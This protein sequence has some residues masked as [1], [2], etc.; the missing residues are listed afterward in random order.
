MTALLLFVTLDGTNYPLASCRWVR[1]APNGCATG[2]H[3]GDAFT[4]PEA[5]AAHFTPGRRDREREHTRGVRYRLVSPD[6]WRD[7]VK[8]CLLDE[9]SHQ[10]AA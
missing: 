2:S 4:S 7:T 1:Y 6:E 8:P 10:T 9:C 3:Y 5:A